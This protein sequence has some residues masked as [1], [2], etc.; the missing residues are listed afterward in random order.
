M[1]NPSDTENYRAKYF[2]DTKKS[3]CSEVLVMT[4]LSGDHIRQCLFPL[5]NLFMCS[6]QSGFGKKKGHFISNNP[7]QNKA[8]I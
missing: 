8:F 5:Q 7:I 3:L 4:Y 1:L 2:M 6:V